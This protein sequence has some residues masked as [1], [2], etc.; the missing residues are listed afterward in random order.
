MVMVWHTWTHACYAWPLPLSLAQ[1]CSGVHQFAAKALR[2]RG[3]GFV[4][5][6]QSL[7]TLFAITT[8]WLSRVVTKHLPYKHKTS[9]HSISTHE[10]AKQ[11][12]NQVPELL[13][14]SSIIVENSCS[15]PDKGSSH[16]LFE[17]S[18]VF[19]KS[20]FH[21]FLEWRGRGIKKLNQA[22]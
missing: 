16:F 4:T 22:C 20:Y 21:H 1:C 5:K 14:A 12:W 10:E 19:C 7:S 11:Y 6:E 17:N 2:R 18:G 15:Y 3:A 8:C 9:C 13:L